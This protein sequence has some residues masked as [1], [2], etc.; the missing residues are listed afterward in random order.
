MIGR[1]MAVVLRL[2][3]RLRGRRDPRDPRD[4]RDQ[5][6]LLY[7]GLRPYQAHLLYGVLRLRDLRLRDRRDRMVPR[8]SVDLQGW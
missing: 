6:L 2:V 7:Q 8:G 1:K 5:G 3:H 4:L